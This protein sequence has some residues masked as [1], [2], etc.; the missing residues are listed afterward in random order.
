MKTSIRNL[1]LSAL[2]LTVI[3]CGTTEVSMP[4]L[5]PVSIP[6]ISGFN[7][8]ASDINN[9]KLLVAA[10]S[11]SDVPAHFQTSFSDAIKEIVME[12]GSEVIDRNMANRFIKEIQLKES[13]SED[14]QAYEGPVEARFAII[15]TITNYSYS[16]EY[17]KSHSSK[18]NSYPAECDYKGSATG[19]VQIRE[20]PS[21]KQLF[22]VNV[23]SKEYSS[24]ENPRSRSCD[25]NGMIVGVIN[26][27]IKSLLVKGHEDYTSLSKYVGSQGV[28]TGARSHGGDMY[29]ETNLGRLHGAKEEAQVA[30][31]QHID[32][33]LVLIAEGEMMESRN[34]L[35]RKAY[36]EVDKELAPTLKRGMIVMLSGKCAGIICSMNSKM[37][38]LSKSL[39]K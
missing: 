1:T 22:S 27:A 25:D 36:F 9:S 15:P 38:S 19:T 29:F 26:K 20:L 32:G 24:Q 33:E 10:G 31:Y 5:A 12:S 18:G 37:K 39:N 14:Y 17:E 21:M 28:I 4:T 11:K 30:V 34:V 13:L 16:S 7:S 23:S 35:Q 8:S 2:T 3:G 6:A